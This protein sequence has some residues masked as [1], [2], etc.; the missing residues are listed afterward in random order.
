M[1]KFKIKQLLKE[2]HMTFQQLADQ[3]GVHRVSLFS[4]IN[5]NPTLSRLEDI[6]KILGVE[7]TDLFVSSDK[8]SV[9]GYLEHQGEIT[10]VNSIADIETFLEEVNSKTNTDSIS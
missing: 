3:L 6:S 10:K 5:K 7:V 8:K 2:R 4:S 9:S 1:E